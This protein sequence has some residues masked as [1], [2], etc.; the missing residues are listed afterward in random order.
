MCDSSHKNAL[1]SN[2]VF[3]YTFLILRKLQWGLF[4]LKLQPLQNPSPFLFFIVL[5]LLIRNLNFKHYTLS[6]ATHSSIFA[7][8]ILMDRRA[9]W[10]TIHR[11]TKS[12]TTEEIQHK[13]S[14]FSLESQLCIETGRINESSFMFAP[15]ITLFCPLLIT[16]KY[17]LAL[18]ELTHDDSKQHI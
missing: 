17:V 10:A 12:D 11:I 9:W 18:T 3:L 14:T 5:L 15:F 16:E 2:N 6:M 4:Q 7:W 1:K 8:R 13:H